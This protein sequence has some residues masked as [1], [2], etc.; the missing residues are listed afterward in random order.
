[1]SCTRYARRTES[2]SKRS[3]VGTA[4][5]ENECVGRPGVRCAHV[6]SIGRFGAELP[7]RVEVVEF[8]IFVDC[9]CGVKVV[10]T[11]ASVDDT[12]VNNGLGIWC[13]HCDV[14]IMTSMMRRSLEE[15]SEVWGIQRRAVRFG[16]WL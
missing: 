4:V 9:S 6:Q 12:V 13:Q 15:G 14:M 7:G 16:T 5:G 3:P 2:R 8:L 11:E 1:V 10:V